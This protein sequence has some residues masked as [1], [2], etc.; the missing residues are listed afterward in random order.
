[1]SLQGYGDL[2]FFVAF[3]Q[4][5]T[6]LF[7]KLS[8]AKRALESH[9]WVCNSWMAAER[10]GTPVLDKVRNKTIAMLNA[11]QLQAYVLMP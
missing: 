11:S 4:I 2:L 1:M 8:L 5:T 10:T 3:Y 9:G 7:A 6:F